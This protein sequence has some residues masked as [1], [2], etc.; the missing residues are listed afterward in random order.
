[1]RGIFL[2]FLLLNAGFYRCQAQ[3][4]LM[5]A[6][7]FPLEYQVPGTHNFSVVI[8][9]LGP[10]GMGSFTIFWQQDGGAVQNI[11]VPAGG[12]PSGLVNDASFTVS[13][14]AAGTYTLKVWVQS[15]IPTDPNPLNDT[16]TK[17]IK[18]LST[19]PKKNVLL[20]VFKH[21]TCCPCYDAAY[22]E[23]T[24]ISLNSTYAVANIYSVSTDS[25]YL[26]EGDTVNTTYYGAHPEPLIDRFKFANLPDIMSSFYSNGT[27]GYA[28]EDYG[29][30]EQYYEPVKV[31]F[32]SV[33]YNAT[34]RELRVKIDAQF[35]DDL[36]GDFR[37]NMYV[38]EDSV[39]AYQGCAPDPNNYYHMHVLRVMAGGPWGLQGSLPTI[40]HNN[41][42]GEYEFVYIIPPA[43][44]TKDM[45]I[46][47]FVQNYD[48]D[49]SKR[50]ILNSEQISFNDALALSSTELSNATHKIN[51]YPNPTKNDLMIDF[52]NNGAKEHKI[53]LLDMNGK[54]LT[55]FKKAGNAEI[56]ISGLANGS[57]II[58]IDDGDVFHSEM[59]IKE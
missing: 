15:V 20:E 6:D 3:A 17:T 54:S 9:D 28:L 33:N 14:P 40:I 23:D 27:G 41:D 21:L 51:I 38:T 37:F 7:V 22:Y 35:Y 34:T 2:L 49:S 43:Y 59:I 42:V 58:K 16:M 55:S 56:N 18:V 39:K 4:D 52:G 50:R 57:Y 24:V 45:R 30:R 29:L 31:S 11:T 36:N 1:M 48:A 47:G 46:I 19:M 10:Q 26:A 8:Q 12:A 44:K 13:F 5:V 32:K 53:S 25:I